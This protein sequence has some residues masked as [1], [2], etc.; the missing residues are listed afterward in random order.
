MRIYLNKEDFSLNNSCI[1]VAPTGTGKTKALIDYILETK[2]QCIFV[3]PLNSIG[4]QVYERSNKYLTLI[5]C[6]TSNNIIGDIH[7][8]LARGKSIIISL[9][10][11]IKYRNMFYSYNIYID[12]CHFLIEY[13]NLMDIENLAQDIRNKKFKKIIGLTATSFGLD[14]LLNLE[15]VSPQ[16]KPKSIKNITLNWMKEFGLEDFIG[17][18]LKIYEKHKKLVVMYNNTKVLYQIQNELNVRNINTKIYISEQKDIQI[19]NEKFSNNFDILLCTSA[20]TTG[21]SINEE[22]YSVYFYQNCDTINTIPQFFS[23][24]RSEKSQ[25]CIIKRF[26]TNTIK[27]I[28]INKHT[29][30]NK[31]AIN[32]KFTES[33]N[34]HLHKIANNIT[35]EILNLFVN[36]S[37]DYEFNY[38]EVF[39]EKSDLLVEQKYLNLIE[40]QQEYFENNIFPRFNI[41]SYKYLYM[42]YQIY[43]IIVHGQFSQN[44]ILNKYAEEYKFYEEHFVP[45]RT[46]F[47]IFY[48]E[49]VKKYKTD[50][51]LDLAQNTNI[52]SIDIKKFEE[53]FLNVPYKKKELKEFC[54]KEFAIKPE[55]FKNQTTIDKFLYQLGYTLKYLHKGRIIRKIV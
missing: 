28:N 14:K 8:A 15:K 34:G 53:K 41:H 18:I 38:G 35:Q 7:I 39:E 11:F 22:Y 4:E 51:G 19:I 17:A 43:D 44:D 47:F 46:D 12:E 29:F 42:I 13:N 3:A 6:E 45:N 10:T 32:S 30:Y 27:E 25:G 5:N 23:R 49:K 54:I 33:I 24:N 36:T 48:F 26:Y 37:N 2:E 20:L 16:V 55:I 40:N 1:F 50:I 21:V 52:N 9:T 31:T